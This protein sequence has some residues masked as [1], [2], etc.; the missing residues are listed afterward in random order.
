MAVESVQLV[1]DSYG[2]ADG[3]WTGR[4]TYTVRFETLSFD[5]AD[6]LTADDGTTTVP[7][8]GDAWA[9]GKSAKATSKEASSTG[10]QLEVQVTVGYSS[11]AEDQQ[12]TIENPL[13]RPTQYSYEDGE[14][15]E[16][17]FRDT[18]DLPVVNSAGDDFQDL[19]QRAV[20]RGYV[21]VTRNVASYNDL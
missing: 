10:D 15:A 5:T 2:V 1:S 17:Y 13:A 4:R 12:Q 7:S 3:T 16:P 20:S 21:T 9:A 8:I 11:K 6:T 19:P 18:D 14:E